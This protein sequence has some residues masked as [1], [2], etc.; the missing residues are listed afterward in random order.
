MEEILSQNEID[1]LL[2]AI[3]SGEMDAEELKKEE[4]EKKIRVYDFK[5]ALRFS[6]DQ[7]RSISRI[8][9]NYAR[10][11]TTFLSS[12]LRTYVHIGVESVDQVP[13]EEFI[14]SISSL[15]VLNIYSMSP[16]KGSMVIEINPNVAYALLDRILGGKGTSVTKTESLTEIEKILLNQI[17]EKATGTLKEAWSSL[18]DVSPVLEEF[19]ENPQFIQMVAPNDTVV[20]VSMSAE[21]GEASGMINLCIPHTLLEPIIPKLSAHY[22]MDNTTDERDEEAFQKLSSNLQTTKVDVQAILGETRI[23]I[24]E[25]LKLGIND[26]VSLEQQIGDP[27]TLTINQEPKFYVQPGQLKKKI[28]VQILEEIE[29]GVNTHE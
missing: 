23:T 18:V 14:R 17:F 8:H 22:W 2:S 13:Y 4:E 12:Q 29:K 26:V 21:I 11:L 19:E 10:M 27:L 24:N 16:L 3:T 9:E 15:T 5:R 20:V 6:K 7:I 25:F 1:V 28:A